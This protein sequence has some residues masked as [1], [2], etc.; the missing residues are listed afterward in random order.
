M[1]Y[2]ALDIVR[3]YKKQVR[4]NLGA[5]D[6]RTWQYPDHWKWIPWQEL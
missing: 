4:G 3:R 1:K 5:Y 2:K 6:A